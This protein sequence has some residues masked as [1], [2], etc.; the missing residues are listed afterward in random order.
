M[1]GIQAIMARL[2]PAGD[3]KPRLFMYRDALVEWDRALMEAMKPCCSEEEI[4]GYVWDITGRRQEGRAPHR[5]GQPRHGLSP[6]RRRT[7]GR[8]GAGIQL[9]ICRRGRCSQWPSLRP[10]RT[11]G[12]FGLCIPP[13]H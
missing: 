5:P 2:R 3:G 10:T 6:L 13:R 4:E 8:P 7:R 1:N 12:V 9:A 11:R